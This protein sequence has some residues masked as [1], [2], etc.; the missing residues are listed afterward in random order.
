MYLKHGG[1]DTAC[2]ATLLLLLYYDIRHNF[3]L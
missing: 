2:L 1:T 3:I